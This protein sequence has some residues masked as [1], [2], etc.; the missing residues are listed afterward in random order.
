MI[1]RGFKIKRVI[2]QGCTNYAVLG[3]LAMNLKQ[4]KKWVDIAMVAGQ[5]PPIWEKH[6]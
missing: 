3:D 1:Y 2:Y 4:A 6:Q 5:K